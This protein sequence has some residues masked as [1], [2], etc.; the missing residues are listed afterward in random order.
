MQEG[1]HDARIELQFAG[2]ALILQDG[3]QQ[4]RVV[5]QRVDGAGAD[6]ARRNI[7]RQIIVQKIAVR[8]FH[9]LFV[10]DRCGIQLFVIFA[11]HAVDLISVQALRR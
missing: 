5:C 1:M 10:N 2:H 4:S 11:H 9:I 8:A 7:L 3:I 6:K